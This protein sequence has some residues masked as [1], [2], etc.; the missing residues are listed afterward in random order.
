LASRLDFRCERVLHPVA[1]TIASIAPGR[2]FEPSS[3]LQAVAEAVRLPTYD[4]YAQA[5]A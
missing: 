5:A 1:A 2:L 3:F 4:I